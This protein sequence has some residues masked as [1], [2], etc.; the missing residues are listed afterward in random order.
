MRKKSKKTSP[1][2]RQVK[3]SKL[4]KHDLTQF[5]RIGKKLVGLVLLDLGTELFLVGFELSKLL[6]DFRISK[7]YPKLLQL[8]PDNCQK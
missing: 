7:F 3:F 8:L 5:I 2:R 6:S 4:E 1:A